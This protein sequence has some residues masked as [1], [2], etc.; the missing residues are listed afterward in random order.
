M[1]GLGRSA[2]AY[3]PTYF[4]FRRSAPAYNCL[5]IALGAPRQPTN[6]P[7]STLSAYSTVTQPLRM[8]TQ[9]SSDACTQLSFFLHILQ[10]QSF[11]TSKLIFSGHKDAAAL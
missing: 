3:C 7:T 9:A 8:H 11:H 1:L 5:T 10:L 2:L 4:S 6:Y